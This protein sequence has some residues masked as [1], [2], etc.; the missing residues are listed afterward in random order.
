[1]G[2]IIW[3]VYITYCTQHKTH[4]LYVEAGNV[5]MD[6]TSL[7]AVHHTTASVM[8]KEVLHNRGGEVTKVV[9]NNVGLQWLQEDTF[10]HHVL[11]QLSIQP[12]K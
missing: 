4:L 9:R 5:Q 1:M 11:H 8:W 10:S 12:V 2:S 6:N 3:Q 7:Q